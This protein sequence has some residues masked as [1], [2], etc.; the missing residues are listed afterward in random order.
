VWDRDNDG[1]ADLLFMSVDSPRFSETDSTEC[2]AGGLPT[3]FTPEQN[4]QAWEGV[5]IFDISNEASPVQIAAVPTDC[6]SHTHTLIPGDDGN[7]YLYV[8]SYPTGGRTEGILADETQ[9]PARPANTR[10]DGTKCLQPHNIISI[11]K[12]PL[13]DPASAEARNADGSYPNVKRV[14]L[15]SRQNAVTSLPQGPTTIHFRGCHDISAFME[16]DRAIGACWREGLM[17][18]I[19]DPFNPHYLRGMTSLDV[20]LLFHSVTLSYDGKVI[21][22]EDESGGGGGDRCRLEDGE[23]DRQGAMLFYNRQLNPLGYFKIDRHIERACT[24]HNYNVLPTTNGRYVLSSA[25]YHG[26]TSMI[27]FTDVRDVEAPHW[28]PVGKEIGYFV[29]RSAP[30]GVGEPVDSDVWSS[31]WYNGFV[32]ASDGLQRGDED[33]PGRGE[34]GV[35]VLS[36]NDPATET[37]VDLP[38]LNPQ[39]QMDLVAQ[40]YRLTSHITIA[41]TGSAFVGQVTAS[42]ESCEVSRTVTVRK[43]RSGPDKKIGTT[44]TD[45]EGRYELRQAS[46]R[47]TYYAVASKKVTDDGFNS[48]TCLKSRSNS[49]GL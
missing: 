9:T 19:S 30:N 49:M 14:T 34:R 27:D 15:P 37:A 5:R 2:G 13:S 21:A 33:Q 41:H 22:F 40:N 48:V 44:T 20:D 42:D 31:Y 38:F 35:D 47:G 45:S 32:Y 46:K 29:A 36:F 39:T 26:G 6:G 17:W 7:V 8:S 10:D 24:A 28:G 23:P 3:G 12:V 11:I 16:I 43:I 25:W 18:D 4:A 1:Q